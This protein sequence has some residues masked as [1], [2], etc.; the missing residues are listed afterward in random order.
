MS[1]ESVW[2]ENGKT[3]GSGFYYRESQYDDWQFRSW[4][5]IPESSRPGNRLAAIQLLKKWDVLSQNEVHGLYSRQ[6]ALVQCS[7]CHNFHPS[8]GKDGWV[9]DRCDNCKVETPKMKCSKCGAYT[10]NS[11]NYAKCDKCK[12]NYQV[13]EA[14]KKP[15]GTKGE[16]RKLP[17][18]NSP[19][20][21][22]QWSV[23]GSAKE[24][25]IV[26]HKTQGANG[27]NVTEDGWACSCG[28]FT[29]NTPREDCKHIL[30]VKLFEG[31]STAAKNIV[32]AAHSKEYAEFLKMKAKQGRA[33]AAS[34][35]NEIKM[36]G[37]STGRKFR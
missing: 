27:G 17:K 37:D 15:I 12:I 35:P 9:G 25:Y 28:A 29:R 8:I 16:V 11:E 26:S 6:Y 33:A 31:M 14:A 10:P 22:D 21:T 20:W 34:D 7:Q 4:T 3:G 13:A 23:V 30:K 32:P 19:M 1:K 2:N 36:V 18:V 24:P 5:T